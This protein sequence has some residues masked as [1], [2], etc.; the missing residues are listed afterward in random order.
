MMGSP[1][2]K[3]FESDGPAVQGHAENCDL[4]KMWLAGFRAALRSNAPR[5]KEGASKDAE[6][7]R[8]ARVN[9]FIL[10]RFEWPRLRFCG[11]E[12]YENTIDAEIDDAMRDDA[13]Q[14]G[15]MP[16]TDCAI[17]GKLGSPD[18]KCPLCAVRQE[19]KA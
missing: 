1:C 3:L 9:G 5:P 11:T 12:T 19:P 7:Y 15:A 8:Y 13:M 10:R 2:G 18:G 14:A 16:E 6:R 4:C 17:H